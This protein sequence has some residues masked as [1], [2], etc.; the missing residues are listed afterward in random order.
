MPSS[1]AVSHVLVLGAL[2]D[3]Q[4]M[5]HLEDHAAHTIVGGENDGCPHPAQTESGH[6]RLLAFFETD[7]AFLQLDTQRRVLVVLA[8]TNS[9]PST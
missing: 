4:Q 2:G 9:L 7:R 3:F 1:Y 6:G 8:H 5:L